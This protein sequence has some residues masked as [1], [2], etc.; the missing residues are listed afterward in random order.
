MGSLS[1]SLMQSMMLGPNLIQQKTAHAQKQQTLDIQKQQEQR[2][3]QEADYN[4]H[5]KMMDVGAKPVIN[6]MVQDT[7][8]IP[9]APDS[10]M[11]GVSSDLAKNL[12][13]PPGAPTGGVSSG[14]PSSISYPIVRKAN[15]GNTVSWKDATGD[16]V[17]YELPDEEAQLHL[18]IQRARGM[19][20]VQQE[21]AA[22]QERGKAMGDTDA[23]RYN[24]DQLGI[25]LDAKYVSDNK[26]PDSMVGTKVSQ[27]NLFDLSGKIVPADTRA[28]ALIDAANARAA[29][30]L[31]RNDALI[32]SRADLE[33]AKE[34]A[35]ARA[36]QATTA[37]HL[38]IANLQRNSPTA[39]ANSASARSRQHI[40]DS[41][42][43]RHEGYENQIA[44][45]TQQRLGFQSALD[46]N[47]DGDAFFNPLSK[48][49]DTMGAGV[50]G[51]LGSQIRGLDTRINTLRMVQ[52]NIRKKNGWGE[53]APPGQD[54]GPFAPDGTSTGAA[55]SGAAPAGNNGGPVASNGVPVG[56][57]EPTYFTR[58][59]GSAA[60]PA[61]A[62]PPG[63][64]VIS[65]NQVAA[66][67]QKLGLDVNAAT[68]KY[69]Q[70][71]F[72]IQ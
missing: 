29:G 71:G 46:S 34:Q 45:L 22:A 13:L 14:M 33:A 44:G 4:F 51:V 31:Q 57:A 6:G 62:T 10:Q 40:L 59:N 28:Q 21:A 36:Q 60:A 61:A 35:A 24:L 38:Q 69:Q 12:N 19:M 47:K 50:R 64:K 7:R 68:K 5:Q 1:N 56:R 9:T 23:A 26:L 55:P 42:F 49:S 48:R 25:P 32:K 67:A 20:P 53:F 11:G 2:A 3:Q 41:D 66:A 27:K 70:L 63:Q 72:T 39:D 30:A 8:E 18:A 54:A 15:P 65:R 43:Q 37:L 58:K 17:S 52:K 16:T